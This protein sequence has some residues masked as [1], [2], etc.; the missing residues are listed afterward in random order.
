MDVVT[1]EL[2]VRL[3]ELSQLAFLGSVLL[4]L[5]SLFRVRQRGDVPPLAGVSWIAL[6]LNLLA[7][8]SRAYFQWATHFYE[9]WLAT[10]ELALSAL[11]LAALVAALNS[12]AA[13]QG[14]RPREAFPAGSAV[15]ACLAT[16]AV[17]GSFDEG[18]L[19]YASLACSVLLEVRALFRWRPPRSSSPRARRF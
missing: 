12:G 11:T 18:G 10:C 1:P 4:M 8:A 13:G 19:A 15:T 3:F 2:I 16:A 5:A 7:S 17:L 14:A 9:H 6:E